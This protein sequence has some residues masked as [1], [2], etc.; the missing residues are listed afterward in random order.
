MYIYYRY[1]AFSLRG[2]KGE[3]T[4]GSALILEPQSRA[5]CRFP[6]GRSDP[7]I[8]HPIY[9][10]Y[11]LE[12][13]LHLRIARSVSSSDHAPS[14]NAFFFF[15]SIKLRRC[16]KRISIRSKR[17]YIYIY[18]YALTNISRGDSLSSTPHLFNAHF[19]TS[20]S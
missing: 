2:Q 8:L 10:Q 5:S 6:I 19:S 12:I 20:M 9:I 18:I 16:T 4:T 17:L 7:M 13:S 15:L 1:V 11:T 14:E 3:R